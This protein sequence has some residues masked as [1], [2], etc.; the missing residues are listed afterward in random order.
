ME[1]LEFERPTPIQS[2]SIPPILSGRDVLASSITGSGK[3]AA[4][5]L[6]L[7]ERFKQ[8]VNTNY[9]KVLIVTPSRELAF[10]CHEMVQQLNKY[11]RLRVSLIIGGASM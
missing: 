8:K 2:L 10:Q 1:D 7:L 3:T 6:P 9:I 5:T 11:L 4:F